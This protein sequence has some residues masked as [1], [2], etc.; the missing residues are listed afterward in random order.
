[1]SYDQPKRKT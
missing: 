1:M